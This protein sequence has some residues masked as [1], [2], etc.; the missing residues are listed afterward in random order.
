MFFNQ[1]LF[2]KQTIRNKGLEEGR[3]KDKNR[4]KKT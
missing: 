4:K 2:C 1:L 3:G